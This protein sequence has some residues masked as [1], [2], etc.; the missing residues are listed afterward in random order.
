MKLKNSLKTLGF[1][2][3]TML[4]NTA[5]TPAMAFDSEP[6]G[7]P[8]WC[9]A[10]HTV[11]FEKTGSFVPLVLS[12]CGVDV[13]IYV[14]ADS[15]RH[16]NTTVCDFDAKNCHL[17]RPQSVPPVKPKTPKNNPPSGPYHVPSN[18]PEY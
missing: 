7:T 12:Y 11:Y 3:M 18:D 6:P 1:M 8:D 17:D 13:A 14:P 2:T 5:A 15:V 4:A 9:P 16:P 10:T